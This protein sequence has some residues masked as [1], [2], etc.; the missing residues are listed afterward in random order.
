M[1]ALFAGLALVVFC[2]CNTA[3]LG[4][5]E[6]I[7]DLRVLAIKTEPPEVSPGDTVTV[8]PLVSDINASRPLRFSVEACVDPGILNGATPTCEDRP[9]HTVIVQDAELTGL[10]APEYTG[11]ATSFSVTVP[12]TIL[13]NRSASEKNNGV[14]YLIFYRV[15][16]ADGTVLLTSY[17]S[18]WAS[19]RA[20]KNT[21]PVLSQILVDGAAAGT[22]PTAKVKLSAKFTGNPTESYVTLDRAG[23]EKTREENIVTSWYI[24]EGTLE[25]PRSYLEEA[26]E[27][28]PPTAALPDRRTVLVGVTRDGRGGESFQILLF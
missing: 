22:L 2:S 1:R 27:W 26:V 6:I 5:Y 17:K 28:T 21:S 8:T 20:V 15:R 12:S 3:R 25:D 7:G 4:Q 14:A 10:A 18:I 11:A 19:T 9:D 23:V 24:S 16:A 13:D